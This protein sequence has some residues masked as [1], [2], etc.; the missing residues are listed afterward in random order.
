VSLPLPASLS[1][2]LAIPELRVA[3]DLGED[4]ARETGLAIG[5]RLLDEVG[6]A[7]GGSFEPG[8]GR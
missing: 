4:H 7:A 3:Q 2:S 1:E 8:A 6:I 5:E